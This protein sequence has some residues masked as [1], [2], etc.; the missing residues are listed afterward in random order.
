MRINFFNKSRADIFSRQPRYT[1]AK[2]CTLRQPDRSRICDGWLSFQSME[3]TLLKTF[4]KAAAFLAAIGVGQQLSQAGFVFVFPGVLFV[5]GA[6]H[7]RRRPQNG[8]RRG[9]HHAG[10]AE[11]L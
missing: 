9:L 6:P 11:F 4:L 5:L 10:G 2:E 1:H 7:R 8:A 3:P